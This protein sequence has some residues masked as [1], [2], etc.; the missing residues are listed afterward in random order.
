MGKDVC[1]GVNQPPLKGGVSPLLMHSS[2]AAAYP[3]QSSGTGK[4]CGRSRRG[5]D[6][7]CYPMLSNVA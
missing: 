4:A 1:T 3:S 2:S 6:H 5:G 7:G